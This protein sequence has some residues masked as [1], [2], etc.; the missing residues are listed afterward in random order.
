MYF[1]LRQGR[2]HNMSIQC[3]LK[4]FESMVLPVLLHGSEICGFQNLSLMD[5]IC[6]KFLKLLLPVRKTTPSYLLYGELG[7]YP[8][9]ISVKLRMIAFW[10]RLLTGKQSKL[11]LLVYSLL[12]NDMNN[13]VYNHKWIVFVKSILDDAGYTHIWIS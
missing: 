5:K 6:N 4:L 12:L 2:Y 9:H 11:S 7:R 10:F 13:Y 3:Q 8:V 1:V